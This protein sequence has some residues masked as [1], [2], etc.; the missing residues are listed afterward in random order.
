MGLVFSALCF[1]VDVVAALSGR[2]RLALSAAFAVA[3]VATYVLTRLLLNRTGCREKM[4]ARLIESEHPEMNNDLVNA[5]D[6]DQR[7]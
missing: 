3:V 4:L 1:Y 7:I 5:I 6:F 2:Q